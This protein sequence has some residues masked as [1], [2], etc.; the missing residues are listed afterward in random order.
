MRIV[1]NAAYVLFLQQWLGDL[2][3]ETDCE[4]KVPISNDNLLFGLNMPEKCLTLLL[5]HHVWTEEKRIVF[6]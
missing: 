2:F 6:D 3:S 4:S 1:C 5:C